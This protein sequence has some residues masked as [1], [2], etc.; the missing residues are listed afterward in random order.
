MA[1]QADE[2]PPDPPSSKGTP[3]MGFPALT[4]GRT[5]VM[6]AAGEG[7]DTVGKVEDKRHIHSGTGRCLDKH[8]TEVALGHTEAA[9]GCHCHSSVAVVGRKP[10]EAVVEN[11]APAVDAVDIAHRAVGTERDT[12]CAG[13]KASNVG[14]AA[15][16]ASDLAVR[17]TRGEGKDRAPLD[18]TQPV[19]VESGCNPVSSLAPE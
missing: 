12:G 18:R 14:D 11:M 19:G 15:E 2:N 13:N 9:E 1:A 10:L 5:A 4:F 3:A 8:W 7:S 6:V 16:W 17:P